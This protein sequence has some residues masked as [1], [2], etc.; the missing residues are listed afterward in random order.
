MSPTLALTM[1]ILLLAIAATLVYLRQTV[2]N[3]RTENNEKREAVLRELGLEGKKR[4]V[5]FFHPYW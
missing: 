1:L 3:I 4:V 2:L 5:G